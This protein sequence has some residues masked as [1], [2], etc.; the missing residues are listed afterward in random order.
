MHNF[1]GGRPDL[2]YLGGGGQKGGGGK[3]YFQNSGWSLLKGE[4]KNSG[5]LDPGRSYGYVTLC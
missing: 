4:L 3:G 2:F 5:G 1:D